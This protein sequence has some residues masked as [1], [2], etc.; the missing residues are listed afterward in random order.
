M[1]EEPG[2]ESPSGG[3]KT[4]EE[5]LAKLNARLIELEQAVAGKEAEITSLK[6]TG[7]E[8]EQRLAT[9]GN[10]FAEAVT[11][12]K[13]VVVKA[14]PEVIEELITG[15]TIESI[16]DSLS[17]ARELVSK[18]RRG[19]R[20]EISLAKVP[21]GAPERTSPDLSTLSSREKIQYAIG[22]R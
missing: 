4:P 21:A 20:S 16:D 9:L 13:A 8:M 2:S 3:E 10:S 15:N 19:V 6:Q 5:E 17:R 1:V 11:S 12:Y 18:V 7:Q 14:N 22:K